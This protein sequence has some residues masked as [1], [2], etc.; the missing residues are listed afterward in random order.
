MLYPFISKDD[1]VYISYYESYTKG[2]ESYGST[3]RVKVTA[4][5]DGLKISDYVDIEKY[6]LIETEVK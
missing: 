6:N 2:S 5:S 1:D 3:E 4:T